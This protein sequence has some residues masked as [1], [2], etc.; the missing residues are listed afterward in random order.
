Q[1]SVYSFRLGFNRLEHRAPHTRRRFRDQDTGTPE[2]FHLIRSAPL[3]SGDD[4]AGMTH[5]PPRRR[6]GAGDETDHGL[7]LL[8]RLIKFGRLFLG[9]AANFTDHHDPLRLVVGEKHL[10]TVDEVRTVD[11]IAADADAGSLAEPRGGGLCYRLVG[12][13]SGARDNTDTSP[14]VDV[15]GHYADLALFGRDHAGAVRPDEAR[16]G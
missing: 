1:Y 11:R 5:P 14:A 13:C 2:R 16:P 7:L 8:N 15:A 4:R 12:K 6:G 10:Q 9:A 3:P